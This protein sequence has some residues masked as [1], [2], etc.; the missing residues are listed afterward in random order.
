MP[1]CA[2]P[3]NTG[4]ALFQKRG[5]GGHGG[6]AGQG[7]PG[8]KKDRHSVSTN[9]GDNVST[10]TKKSG[11]GSRTNSKGELHCFHCGAADHWAYEYPELT[12][13]QQGQ[14]QM[15]VKVQDNGGGAQEEGNQLLNVALAQGGALPDN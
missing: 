5:K 12:G 14:L 3:N 9:M 15:N 10:M 6:Q 1:Y 7:K 2:S 11:D 8:V 13:E 4:V